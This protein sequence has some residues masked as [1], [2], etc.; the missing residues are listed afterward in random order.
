MG[1][2]KFVNQWSHMEVYVISKK[3]Q[4]DLDRV[5]PP[6]NFFMEDETKFVNETMEKLHRYSSPE[7][8]DSK[9]FVE[10]YNT[11]DQDNWYC[12]ET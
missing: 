9:K 6:E 2:I 5:I 11:L 8:W 3:D 4:D 7:T 10:L 1:K 12:E